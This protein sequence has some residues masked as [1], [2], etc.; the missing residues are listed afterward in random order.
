MGG[1]DK[2]RITGT[3]HTS[4]KARLTSVPDQDLYRP[5]FLIRIR[6][7]GPDRHQNLIVCSLAHCQPSLE[8]SYKSVRKFLHKVANRPT[9]RQTNN[10]DYITSLAEVINAAKRNIYFIAAFILFYC[11]CANGFTVTASNS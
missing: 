2:T 5:G 8:I 11:T 10:D 1:H 6:I 7:R 9:N 4:T 3:V